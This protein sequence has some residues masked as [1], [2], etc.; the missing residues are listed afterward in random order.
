MN[1]GQN[2]QKTCCC[3]RNLPQKKCWAKHLK[4]CQVCIGLPLN[5]PQKNTRT[6]QLHQPSNLHLPEFDSHPPPMQH[7][8]LQWASWKNSLCQLL[9]DLGIRSIFVYFCCLPPSLWKKKKNRRNV[10]LFINF[11]NVFEICFLDVGGTAFLLIQ[12]C[13]QVARIHPHPQSIWTKNAG[14]DVKQNMEISNPHEK[15]KKPLVPTNLPAS[16]GFPRWDQVD[17]LGRP[18]RESLKFVGTAPRWAW[19]L[20]WLESIHGKREAIDAA[21]CTHDLNRYSVS[22]LW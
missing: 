20:H 18:R 11:L 14:F 9:Q 5:N 4:I 1:L 12:G 17:S 15:M 13:F 3:K 16:D 22:F 6:I 8:D 21:L 7:Q 10:H 2:N 19:F